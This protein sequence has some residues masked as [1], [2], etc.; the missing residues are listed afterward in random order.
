MSRI[1]TAHHRI[2]SKE[3]RNKSDEVAVAEALETMRKAAL[4]LLHHWKK[5]SNA[6]FHFKLEVEYPEY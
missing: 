6:K 2:P 1:I 4:D 5:D 3:C